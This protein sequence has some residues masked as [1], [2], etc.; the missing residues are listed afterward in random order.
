ME[1]IENSRILRSEPPEEEELRGTWPS[2]V[3]KAGRIPDRLVG[4]RSST[5]CFQTK[6]LIFVLTRLN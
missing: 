4:K 3:G 6:T 1:K 5:A 2:V